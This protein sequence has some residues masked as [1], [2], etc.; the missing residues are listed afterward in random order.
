M[1]AAEIPGTAYPRWEGGDMV[2]DNM[3]CTAFGTVT[4]EAWQRL[5]RSKVRLSPAFV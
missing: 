2:A 1:A 4:S 3:G 5:M